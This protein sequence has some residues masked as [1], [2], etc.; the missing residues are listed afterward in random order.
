MREYKKMD[1][2]FK[3]R[4]A[5]A[6]QMRD[7]TQADLSQKCGINPHM[8]SDFEAGIKEPCLSDLK[9]ISIALEVSIDYLIGIRENPSGGKI[10]NS[11]EIQFRRLMPEERNTIRSLVE[12]LIC[13]KTLHKPEFENSFLSM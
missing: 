5:C 13:K 1:A 11:F 6:R 7:L 12:V 9:K 2:L 10:R 3:E 4:L 8:I